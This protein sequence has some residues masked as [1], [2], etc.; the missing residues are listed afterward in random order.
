[1]LVSCFKIGLSDNGISGFGG[2]GYGKLL[3]LSKWH[4]NGIA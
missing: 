4:C 3:I 2:K 1:M